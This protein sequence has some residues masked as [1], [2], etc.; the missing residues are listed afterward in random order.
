MHPVKGNLKIHLK[1]KERIYI[2]GAILRVDRRVTL[3]LLNEMNFLLES[4]VLQEHEATTPL[5]QLYFVIQSILIEPHARDL[6]LQIYSAQHRRLVATNKD[7]DLLESLVEVKAMVEGGRTYEALKR[8]R[9]LF[10]REDDEAASVRTNEAATL[11]E[12]A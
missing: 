8:I 4:H 6:A 12:L 2:N 5:R 3:E 9:G 7:F 1:P 10:I 11:S